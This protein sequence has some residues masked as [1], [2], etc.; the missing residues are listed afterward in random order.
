MWGRSVRV[1]PGSN[2]S[3]FQIR[4]P[5]AEFEPTTGSLTMVPERSCPVTRGNHVPR[6]SVS[7][8]DAPECRL[9]YGV[10]REFITTS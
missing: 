5:Q 9:K 4:R 3:R 2:Y 6:A 8:I 10:C 7:S 1:N